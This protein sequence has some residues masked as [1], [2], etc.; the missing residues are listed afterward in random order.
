MN[1]QNNNYEENKDVEISPEDT[2]EDDEEKSSGLGRKIIITIIVIALL[3]IGAYYLAGSSSNK[4][5]NNIDQNEESLDQEIN[6]E[7]NKEIMS[8][9]ITVNDQLAGDSVLVSSVTLPVSGWVAIEDNLNGERGNTLGAVWLP[10]GSHSN[11]AI[12]LLRSTISGS[13][14]FVVLRSDPSG[15]HVFNR[16]EDPEILN[17]SGE[18]IITGFKVN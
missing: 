16:Q 5:E 18:I 11:Q 12:E 10:S 1:D 15:D 9:L 7:S 4:S 14:Y 17:E 13:E 3:V 6:E 2:V 8:S